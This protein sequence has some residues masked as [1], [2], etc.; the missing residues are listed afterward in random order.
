MFK[1]IKIK[2]IFIFFI[3]FLFSIVFISLGGCKK[4]SL[5]RVE[6]TQ[7]Y[8]GTYVSIIVYAD[9]NCGNEIIESA[10]KKIEELE[11]IASNYD[12]NSEVCRLNQQ[13]YLD[14][15]S[16]ELLEMID[17][18]IEY[19]KITDG[20]FDITIEPLLKLWS[21]GLWKES[22][23]VQ[24]EKISEAL[25][26]VGSE[27][28][29]IEN[30]KI[31]FELDGMSVT[32]GGIAKGYIIDKAMDVIQ[33]AGVESALINAGGDIVSIGVKDDGEMWNI[34]LENPDNTDESIASFNFAGKAVATSG[35]YYRYFDPD[36]EVH[37]IIDP[38]T[39]FSADKCISV[40]VIAETC[41]EADALATSVFVMG[42]QDGLKLVESLDNVEALIIDSERNIY[43]SSGLSKYLSN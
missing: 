36:K 34:S 31:E 37:H 2:V 40:T 5:E 14:E 12:E 28:I 27:K 43:K 39:G 8:M 3:I 15:A 42:S 7:Q 9:K 23:E 22:E 19:Y 38:K 32:L 6:E 20:S 18:S 17:L 16:D 10:Y 35:N 33:E 25:M 41:T 21:E 29:N 26:L 30:R 13:G 11:R 24:A 4:V 1:G